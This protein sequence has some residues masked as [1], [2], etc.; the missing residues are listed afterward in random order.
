MPPHP[1]G[2]GRISPAFNFF[3]GTL[4]A[5]DRPLFSK[6]M[7]LAFVRTV[8][9]KAGGASPGGRHAAS[10]E[11]WLL[12]EQPPPRCGGG[13]AR[14]RGRAVVARAVRICFPEREEQWWRSCASHP[15]ASQEATDVFQGEGGGLRPGAAGVGRSWPPSFLT[16]E[17]RRRHREP[18]GA[19]LAS[20]NRR[21][22]S[23]GSQRVWLRDNFL[24]R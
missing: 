20:G 13:G 17:S 18:L 8:T 14:T 12:A 10:P 1:A 11:R 19:S 15:P 9:Q 21:C 23:T 4:Q 5:K 3:T 22:P 24:F 2:R 16:A 7:A 6:Q